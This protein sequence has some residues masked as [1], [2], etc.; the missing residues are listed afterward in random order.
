M[1]FLV[2]GGLGVIGS[3]LCRNLMGDKHEV[4]II[5]SAEEPRN[6]WVAQQL[7]KDGYKPEVHRHRLENCAAALP[8]LLG[9]MDRVIHCA[10][11]TGIPYSVTA[12]SDDWLSNAEAT[13]VLLNA[14][15]INPRPTVVLSSVKPYRVSYAEKHWWTKDWPGLSE[16]TPLDPDEPYAAS[17]AAQSMLC[18]A[19]AKSYGIPVVTFR[20]SNLYGQAPCH[21]PRHGWLTWF[22]ISAAIKRPIE[23]QGTGEQERDM[24]HASDVY[25]ACM[26]ALEGAD[27]LKGEIFNLG[28]GLDKVIS[29]NKAAELL[30]GMTDVKLVEAPAREMDDTH[31]W[32][33]YTKFKLATG[34]ESKV[35]VGI[36]LHGV[37]SWARAN[38]DD[39]IKLYENV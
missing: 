13:R 36:G 8:D 25:S 11:S 38:A 27:K 32:V 30:Q 39:L 33:D 16:D 26:L 20:C 12:P 31:V 21:G 29:V 7:V 22:A 18:V 3:L 24:L 17:K 34:W 23:I 19:Y 1:K 10:A 2:T 35:P 6:E 5:D 37:F 4:L 9:T 28:G 14:L 15:R